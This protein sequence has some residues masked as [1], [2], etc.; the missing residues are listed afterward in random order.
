MLLITTE[1]VNL[2]HLIF[3]L[4]R[5]FLYYH[6]IKLPTITNVEDINI[7]IGNV[8]SYTINE[9]TSIQGSIDN[10][11]MH[12]DLDTYS[13]IRSKR[14]KKNTLNALEEELQN[15]NIFLDVYKKRKDSLIFKMMPGMYFKKYFKNSYEKYK[16]IEDV[17]KHQQEIENEIDAH[18][19]RDKEDMNELKVVRAYVEKYKLIDNDPVTEGTIECYYDDCPFHPKN[20][21][22]CSEGL[23]KASTEQL[24]I[25]AT[26]KSKKEVL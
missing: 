1:V 15:I 21:P 9:I 16:T 17:F 20:E 6:N 2:M 23:C 24:A 18:N 11:L 26:N 19:Q 12:I 14:L 7:N 22:F 25:Y 5:L 3:S 13:S 8:I 10:V 4:S